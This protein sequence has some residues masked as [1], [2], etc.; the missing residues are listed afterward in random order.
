MILI[1]LDILVL[2][3][4][5][6]GLPLAIVIAGAFMRETGT[7]IT[8]YLQYYQESWFDV[9]SQS[10]PG[11]QYQQGN[12]LQT[13]MISYH[14]IQKRDPHAAELLLLLARFDNRDIWYG[15]VKGGIYSSNVPPWLERTVSN[16]LTFKISV[17][18][19]IGFSLSKH[20]HSCYYGH[21]NH[22][23]CLWPEYALLMY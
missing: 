2:A 16:G 11:R 21:A 8:E 17:K 22:W 12:M 9:Q 15:L 20:I 5:L 7:S 1:H 23:H 14:E 10:S 6:D 18:T 13:W 3:N 19:L 4:R